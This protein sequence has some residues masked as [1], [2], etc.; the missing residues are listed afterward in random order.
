MD[1]RS[2]RSSTPKGPLWAAVIAVILVVGIIAWYGLRSGPE[3][4]PDRDLPD[5]PADTVADDT[6]PEIAPGTDVEPLDLPEL[7]GSDAFVR[8]LV[9]GLS[10]HPQLARWLVTDGLIDRYV[11][12]VLDLAGGSSPLEHVEFLRPEEDFR[13][14]SGSGDRQTID[15]ESYQRWNL[16]AETFASLDVEGTVRLH[17]QLRP[18][19]EEAWEAR[20]IPDMSFDH[21]LARA[22]NTLRD[23]EIPRDPPEV[24]LVEGIWEFADPELEALPGAQKALIR[25]GPENADRIRAQVDALAVELG[26]N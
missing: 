17:R 9:A 8:D 20:G 24:V 5:F 12:V 4:G 16:L 11:S 1:Y 3:P 2:R 21:A 23:A 14:R 25:M 7:E 26:L 18:L 22:L 13:V 19:I 10:S 6:F 15:P